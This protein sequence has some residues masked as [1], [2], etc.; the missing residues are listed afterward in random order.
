ANLIFQTLLGIRAR[1][2]AQMIFASEAA[3][4]QAR[5]RP[6]LRDCPLDAVFIDFD[7][8]QPIAKLAIDPIDPKIRRLIAVTVRR[9]HQVFVR[10]V[11]SRR[12]LPSGMSGSLQSPTVR[13]VDL[14]F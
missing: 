1:L 5:P 8:R 12:A 9:D 13:F 6:S 11:G 2:R 3:V 14:A 7:S 10:V 4:E